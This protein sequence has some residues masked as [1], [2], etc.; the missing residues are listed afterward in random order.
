MVTRY[1]FIEIKAAISPD[2]GWITDN[3]IVTRAGIFQYRLPNGKVRRE[4]RTAEEV[5]K[6]DSLATYRGVPITDGHNGIIT[7]DNAKGIIGTV[8]SPGAQDGDNVR[9]ELIIHDPNKLG[10]RKELSCGYTCDID[11]TP[12]SYQGTDYDCLQRNIRI[13]HLAVVVKGRA[14]NARL[15]LDSDDA[16]NGLFEQENEMSEVKLAVVKLDNIDYQA[17]PEV[18]NALARRQE[19][20]DALQRRFDSI[21]AERDT[22]KASAEKHKTDIEKAKDDT[23]EEM[24]LRGQVEELA[25][26]H[27]I[28]FDEADSI[29]AVKKKVL[30][31]LRPSLK[32]EEKSD[33]YVSSA[34]DLTIEAEAEK[35]KKVSKQIDKTKQR[36]DDNAT[37]TNSAES[38]RAKDDREDARSALSAEIRLSN[39]YPGKEPNTMSQSVTHGPY[40][41][42]QSQAMI[43]MKADSMND[44]VDTFAAA[45]PIPF[46]VAVGRVAPFDMKVQAGGT[47]FVGVAIHD[48]IIGSRGGYLQYDAVSVLTR[49]RCWV[50]LNDPLNV[51]DG[52]YAHFD[53]ATGEFYAAAGGPGIK[54]IN[55]VFRSGPH[56]S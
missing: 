44:N 2:T 55:A 45:A 7:K 47:A 36:S 46:G 13:N 9:A 51:A 39:D 33:E 21:E 4:L 40:S 15:R 48:H 56:R 23:R 24:K 31:K 19:Q 17:S 49:G 41:V 25:K 11:D 35:T 12:G 10:Q 16:V 28:N 52:V 18:I 20:L 3:P 5:F 34:F 30:G 27:S 50:R 54:M 29:I 43:G 42:Y 26:Q 8:I 6:A 14:G 32:L 22:L 53:P 1:D 38:S 37:E